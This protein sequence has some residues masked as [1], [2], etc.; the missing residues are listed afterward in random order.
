MSHGALDGGCGREQVPK[1]SVFGQRGKDGIWVHVKGVEGH[2]SN[3]SLD[4]RQKRSKTYAKS[5][6]MGLEAKQMQTCAFV[7]KSAKRTNVI[8]EILKESIRHQDPNIIPG[9]VDG[10]QQ[11]ANKKDFKESLL[12]ASIFQTRSEVDIGGQI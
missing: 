8:G 6:V 11:V 7:H 2:R 12:F 5:E 4:C 1:R 9:R 3:R 10:H